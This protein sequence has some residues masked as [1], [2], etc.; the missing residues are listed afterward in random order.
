MN[1]LFHRTDSNF[2]Y[3][4][5]SELIKTN[6]RE[7]ETNNEGNVLEQVV[8]GKSFKE[9]NPEVRKMIKTNEG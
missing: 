3:L 1:K 4:G 2:Y 5:L 8:G 9:P 7:G 6:G